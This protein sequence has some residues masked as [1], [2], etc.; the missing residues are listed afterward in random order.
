MSTTEEYI[1][2]GGYTYILKHTD[3]VGWFVDGC[4]GCLVT[5]YYENREECLQVAMDMIN[6]GIGGVRSWRFGT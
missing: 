6:S 4:Y 3:A 2:V 5:G 1:E